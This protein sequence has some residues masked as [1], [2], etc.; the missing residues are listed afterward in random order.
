MKRKLLSLLMALTMALSLVP[1]S[2]LAAS[3]GDTA[4]HWAQAAIER[5][6]GYG[7]V[8]GDASGFRPN[9][10]MTRA[11]AAT[12]F[13]RLF[14]LTDATAK[15]TFTDVKAGDWYYDAVNKCVN[16]GIM[17]GVGDGMMKPNSPLTREMFFVMFARGLGIKEQSA[18]KGLKA[19][20]AAW[21][22][23]YINA[24]TDKGYVKGMDGKVNA[25]ANI[26]RASVMALLDQT[27]TTYANEAGAT[28]TGTGKGVTLIA[29]EGVTV[30]GNVD[31][32]V[33]AGSS[34]AETV[35]FAGDED[36]AYASAVYAAP[37]FSVIIRNAVIALLNILAPTNVSLEGATS[38]SSVAVTQTAAETT[39]DVGA[40][41]S[42]AAVETAAAETKVEGAG[43]VEAVAATGEAADTVAVTTPNT[44]VATSKSVENADGST[45]TTVTESKNDA[46]G[47]STGETKTETTVK[48][49]TAADGT[50]TTEK[51]ATATVTNAAGKVTETT[52]T[53]STVTEKTASD[54]TKTTETAATVT[55]ADGTGKVVETTKTASTVKE[56]TAADGTKTTETAATVAKTDAAGKTET[57]K[58]DATVTEKTAANGTKTTETAA[59]VAKTDAS[60]KTETTTTTA[61]ATETTNA[62]GSVTTAT[63]AT[64]EK[65][66]ADG[67][68]TTDKVESTATATTNA[69]GSTTTAKT[70]T[71]ATTGADGKT[72]TTKTESTATATVNANGT[73]TTATEAKVEKTD[74]SGKTTTETVKS[75]ETAKENADG[76]TTAT[77]TTSTT[78]ASGRTTTTTETK[79]TTEAESA[80]S[81]NTG[82]ASES[83]D[84]G[85]T[86]EAPT[87]QPTTPSTS[88]GGDDGPT[89]Y[90]VVFDRNLSS[91]N[92]DAALV[93]GTINNQSV[94]SGST[95][96]LPT[97]TAASA[98]NEASY[99]LAGWKLGDAIYA[100]G[101]SYT[102]SGS[103]TFVAQWVASTAVPRAVWGADAK[104]VIALGASQEDGP[105]KAA[106]RTPVNYQVSAKPSATTFT[107]EGATVNVYDVKATG[108]EAQYHTA[109]PEGQYGGYYV[110]FFIPAE[111]GTKF[112]QG[113][114]ELSSITAESVSNT[115][116]SAS[117]GYIYHDLPT[118]V[119][120]NAK[121]TAAMVTNRSNFA[122]EATKDMVGYTYYWDAAKKESSADAAHGYLIVKNDAGTVYN[123]YLFD[124]SE[125]ELATTY[126]VTYNDDG[127]K[128][129]IGT[130]AALS[131]NIGTTASEI[132]AYVPVSNTSDVNRIKDKTHVNI[133]VKNGGETI[134]TNKYGTLSGTAS[135]A[136]GKNY[137]AVT[138]TPDSGAGYAGLPGT[139]E[140]YTG[141]GAAEQWSD[142][143]GTSMFTLTVAN[144]GDKVA[145]T[146]AGMLLTS[147]GDSYTP[148]VKVFG[149]ATVG[150][151]TAS[152]GIVVLKGGKLT[153]NGALT[154]DVTVYGTLELASGGSVNGTITEKTGSTVTYG[155]DVIATKKSSTTLTAITGI[156][157]LQNALSSATSGDVVTLTKGID[158]SSNVTSGTYI[159]AETLSDGVTFSGGNYTITCN[160]C[161]PANL[162]DENEGVYLFKKISGK[163]KNLTFDVTSDAGT[164]TSLA[165]VLGGANI[166]FDN[167]TVQGSQNVY[168]ND[169]FFAH[170]A[171]LSAG[172]TTVTATFTDCV[173]NVNAVGGGS[174]TNYNAAFIGAVAHT[175]ANLTFSRCENKGTFVCGKT[176]L[177][178]GNVYHNGGQ[179]ATTVTLNVDAASKNTGTMRSTYVGNGFKANILIA[180][181]S[182]DSTITAKVNNVAETS[183]TEPRTSELL[184]INEGTT[185]LRGP[186]DTGMVLTKNGA[187]LTITPATDGKIN[188]VDVAKYIVVVATHMTYTGGS[189]GAT[190]IEAKEEITSGLNQPTVTLKAYSF[191]TEGYTEKSSYTQEGTLGGFKTISND[192]TTYY[193][194]ENTAG[195]QVFS[196]FTGVKE[197]ISISLSAYDANGALLG[198]VPATSAS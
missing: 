96:T 140:F 173:V 22:A 171:G 31:T 78:D 26:N 124:F 168:I 68:K 19:D 131:C 73:T 18:T 190:W 197:P 14:S 44:E 134:Y 36:T 147:L 148:Q 183:V 104:S 109:G 154:G 9:D 196:D 41:A 181:H 136:S 192:G 54:G 77:T 45:T 117:D 138:L 105:V 103:V 153:V 180:K 6:S 119:S 94:T 67:T 3:Y 8:T 135:A 82:A 113:Y 182:N 27:I 23:G 35:A 167:V 48:E 194:V 28:V 98:L 34:E 79:T 184:N 122:N 43:K 120:S 1:V 130:N 58:T 115:A 186:E 188:G 37:R 13:S 158:V 185:M 177:F 33:V 193:L 16:A 150:T 74:A 142:V 155:S 187:D 170:Y 72:T 29:A 21:S 47:K 110:G 4:G 101:A 100:P 38:V 112:L 62:N 32:L 137:Y 40:N 141:T 42:V 156:S 143:S 107:V 161:N 85:S 111:A 102:V 89:Y 69:D 166:E 59:T 198:S 51:T 93:E 121:L 145:V 159:L 99:T 70:E 46:A 189:G 75:T 128:F 57:T 65:T 12:V 64:V 50:K 146:D 178:I 149:D 80:V 5:W 126:S 129:Y 160:T 52:K 165:Y 139:V 61:T 125:V 157:A 66:A 25:T 90:S 175:T 179:P 76:S 71:V 92:I 106:E 20:G 108:T 176:A 53:E 83:A 97:G 144:S 116:A 95:V 195:V 86:S 63:T 81:S 84:T 169:G 88:S 163:V 17:N 15:S 162:T 127:E 56:T 7:I 164:A 114:G 39:V 123:V 172:G 151:C 91:I 55:K 49:T 191:V 30:T 133:A 118:D 60:G 174:D 2:A 152:G 132:K 87:T 10:N 11:E 24:L